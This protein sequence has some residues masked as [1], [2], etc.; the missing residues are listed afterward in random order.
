MND[1]AVHVRD[2]LILSTA[3]LVVAIAAGVPLGSV[4]ARFPGA[5]NF[6][7]ASVNVARVIPSLAVL[8]L[9]QPILGIGFWPSLVALVLLAI[10]PIAINTDV[11]LRGV[12]VAIVD[13]ARGIGMNER[14]VRARVTW[15]LA[16]PIVMAGIRTAAVEVI[17]SATLAAFIGGGGLGEYI[18]NGLAG[19]DNGQL[20]EGAISVGILALL[21]QG[22]LTLAERRLAARA[23]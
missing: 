11:G 7:L 15:P 17:S 10:P 12:P 9:A 16:L 20:Y 8:A 1:L 6:S 4:I 22:L 3:A 21:A 2:H 13:A 23:A 14:Q 18:L 19:G 5:R